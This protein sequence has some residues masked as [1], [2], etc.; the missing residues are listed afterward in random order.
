MGCVEV[1]YTNWKNPDGLAGAYQQL[2]CLQES[3]F[4]GDCATHVLEMPVIYDMILRFTDSCN[5]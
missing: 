1:Y 2:L 4:L 3:H 5:R